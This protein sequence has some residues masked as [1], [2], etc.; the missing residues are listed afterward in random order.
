MAASFLI[1]VPL[2]QIHPLVSLKFSW[3]SN[4]FFYQ[5]FKMFNSMFQTV[6]DFNLSL[7]YHIFVTDFV[8]SHHLL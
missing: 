8:L 3:L 4:N 7:T 6:S 2:P 1:K 5:L